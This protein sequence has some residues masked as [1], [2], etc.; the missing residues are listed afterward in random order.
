MTTT[1]AERPAIPDDEI[2]EW[3]RATGRKVSERG[4]VGAAVRA[5]YEATASQIG[6]H[7]DAGD[8]PAERPAPGGPERPPE[9]PRPAAAERQPRP[10]RKTGSGWRDRARALISGTPPSPAG[11]KSTTAKAPPR[12]P[13]PRTPVTRVVERIWGQAAR[14]YEHIN[15]PVART[16]AWQAPY[17]GIVAEDVIKGTPLDKVLQVAARVEGAA[18]G[19]GS[20]IAMPFIVGAITSERNNPD[21]HGLAAVVRQQLLHSALDECIDSQ[22][23]MFG[24][25]ELVAKIA[26]SA[27]EHAARTADIERI[28]GMIF[29]AMPPEPDIPENATPAQMQAA[30][31]E[32]ARAAAA[33]QAMRQAAAAVHFMRPAEPD[34]R[35]LDAERAA[36]SMAASAAAAAAGQDRAIAD[37]ARM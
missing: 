10:V 11:K 7:V 13:R 32:A 17:I 26:K 21:T 36:A 35:G 1:T 6:A 18:S 19:I 14:A 33:E 9:R 28:R 8:P 27:E 5:E 37:A 4:K 22:L 25:A 2:R 29:A 20:M 24:N 12:E 16:M 34:N 31:A 15:V 3:A 23:E 30:E